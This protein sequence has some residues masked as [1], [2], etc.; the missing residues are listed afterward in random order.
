[1]TYCHRK[2]CGCH[3]NVVA[4]VPNLF[5]EKSRNRPGD[6]HQLQIRCGNWLARAGPR[7]CAQSTKLQFGASVR[8]DFAIQADL[9]KLRRGPF[10]DPPPFNRCRFPDSEFTFFN[11]G[12]NTR[13][14]ARS[15]TVN[16]R[17]A[18]SS[19]CFLKIVLQIHARIGRRPDQSAPHGWWKRTVNLNRCQEG[20]LKVSREV[21]E[22]AFSE[23]ARS[24]AG[25]PLWSSTQTWNL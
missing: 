12:A 20:I 25:S 23:S 24:A 2:T 4:W 14:R 3:A 9:L 18:S 19:L 13:A 7:T 17:V 6:W 5:R 8:V 10:H 11:A 22:Q 21:F 1:M 15:K 16:L